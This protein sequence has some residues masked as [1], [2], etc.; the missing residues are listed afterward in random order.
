MKRLSFMLSA[1]TFYPCRRAILSPMVVTG[2]FVV[3]LVA[4]DVAF[5]TPVPLGPAGDRPSVSITVP[6]K[7][8]NNGSKVSVNIVAPA[9]KTLSSIDLTF[10]GGS[11]VSGF[12]SG[13][14][15]VKT[16]DGTIQEHIPIAGQGHAVPFKGVNLVDTSVTVK[17]NFTDGSTAVS[18]TVETAS[19]SGPPSS[20]PVIAFAG[21]AVAFDSTTGTLAFGSGSVS[22]TSFSGDTLLG[23]SVLT[24]TYTLLGLS[25]DGSSFIFQDESNDSASLLMQTGAG[26]VFEADAPFLF[27]DIA[28][29]EF[30][31]ELNMLGL[32]GAP[33]GTSFFDPTLA[34]V[35]SPSLTLLNSELNPS[36]AGFLGD[37]P[38]GASF[39]PGVDFDALTDNFG[40]S[41]SSNFASAVFVTTP[42]PASVW[43]FV[44]GIVALGLVVLRRPRQFHL[45]SGL[46]ERQGLTSKKEAVC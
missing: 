13:S 38:L 7:G 26:T 9:G 18:A 28:N 33:A 37:L 10:P 3:C 8:T 40:A 31:T 42:E 23:A 44:S 4:S 43:M 11:D 25:D 14:A 16:Q 1:W 29:N 41:G 21:T 5:A 12:P 39:T 20:L 32:A 27:Y 36:G 17:L 34:S 6:K 2:L 15:P 35:L 22:G 24:P 30:S 45:P 46:I 19:A